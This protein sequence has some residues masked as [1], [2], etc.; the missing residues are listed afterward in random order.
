[1]EQR[2]CCVDREAIGDAAGGARG[3]CTAT[4]EPGHG[5]D[6]ECKLQRALGAAARSSNRVRA[7]VAAPGSCPG[8]VA[9]P[10]GGRVELRDVAELAYNAP[11]ARRSRGEREGC[12][13]GTGAS[14][15]P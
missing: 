11:R 14:H 10:L 4:R 6:E 15:R 8:F 12:R 2:T 5:G 7:T 13:G 9:V 1:M 3:D